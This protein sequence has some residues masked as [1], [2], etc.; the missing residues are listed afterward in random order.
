MTQRAQVEHVAQGWYTTPITLEERMQY[1]I[2]Y[3]TKHLVQARRS[4]ADPGEFG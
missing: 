1:I 3:R 2:L 4:M